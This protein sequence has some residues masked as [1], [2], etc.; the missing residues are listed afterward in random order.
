MKDQPVFEFT[1]A[2]GKR[3]KI[4]ADGRIQGLELVGTVINR[5]PQLIAEAH[6]AGTQGKKEF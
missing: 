2:C 5:I 6:C 3:F 4:Y 1:T